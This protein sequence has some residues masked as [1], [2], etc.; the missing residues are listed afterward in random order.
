MYHYNLTLESRAPPPPRISNSGHVPGRGLVSVY[1]C[2]L[3]LESRAPPP[4]VSRT[5]ATSPGVDLCPCI[6][7]I[8]PWNLVHPPPPYLELRPRPRAWTCVSA[9]LACVAG[10]QRGGRG[11]V[12][13]EREARSLGP[14]IALRAR[15]QLPPFLP[16]VR[17]P[18]R[19]VHRCNFT[20]NISSPPPPYLEL[21]PRPRAA[22][23]RCNFT[24]DI[25]S[26]PVSR[27]QATSPGV[28]LCPC[29]T[30]FFEAIQLHG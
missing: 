19:L 30:A 13:C 11:E 6:T 7:V 15:I 23:H 26:P 29:I 28:D 12:E 5:Q 14:T 2:N 20:L 16:F 10:V 27:T 8:L 22:V 1:H 9:S 18:R 17:R 3:T 4:P 21:R 25:S 24:L